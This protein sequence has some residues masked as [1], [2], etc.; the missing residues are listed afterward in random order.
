MSCKRHSA[1]L[2]STSLEVNMNFLWRPQEE[3]GWN[4]S[5]FIMFWMTALHLLSSGEPIS[6]EHLHRAVNV[7]DEDLLV[8]ILQGG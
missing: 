3:Q 2:P 1:K 4:E 8:H 7:N 6:S 5:P